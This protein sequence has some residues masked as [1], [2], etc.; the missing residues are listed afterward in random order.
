MGDDTEKIVPILRGQGFETTMIC[1]EDATAGKIREALNALVKSCRTG[2]IVYLHFSCH[3]QPFEDRDGDEGKD[4]GWDESIVPYDAQMVFKKGKYKGQNHII[5]DELHTYFQKIREKIGETRF[6]C[7]VVDACHAGGSSRGENDTEDGDDDVFV[8]G[9]DIGFSRS[10]KDY[11]PS[12]KER[13]YFKIQEE[14]GFAQI[15]ILE[16]CGPYEENREIKENNQHYGPLSYYV[17]E[18]LK[19]K[20]LLCSID[21]ISEVRKRMNKDN[22]LTMQHMYIETTLKKHGDS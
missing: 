21:W 14:L 11:E 2:D 19:E 16:A 20:K 13:G 1:N 3:G 7:V 15:A 22:R 8:R 5:D 18:V 4:D 12:Q 6:V 10:G 17:C 9:T